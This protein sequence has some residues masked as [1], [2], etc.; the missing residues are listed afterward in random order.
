MLFQD[1]TK[2]VLEGSA[3]LRSNSNE[4]QFLLANDLGLYDWHAQWIDG[5]IRVHQGNANRH[6]ATH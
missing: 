6:P 5:K 3:N 1:Q 4:E 2:L